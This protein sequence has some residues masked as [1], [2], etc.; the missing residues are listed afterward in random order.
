MQAGRLRALY[1]DALQRFAWGYLRDEAAA[2]DLVQE[3]F[4][5]AIESGERPTKRGR[6]C[7]ASPAT[8]A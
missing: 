6:G 8:C 1:G 5:R 2:E 7:T 3:V 4:L